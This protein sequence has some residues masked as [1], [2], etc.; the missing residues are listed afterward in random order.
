MTRILAACRY[1]LVVPLIGC[2]VLIQAFDPIFSY[3]HNFDIRK[4]QTKT[5]LEG[6][7]Q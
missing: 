4:R 5:K 3:T 1:L 2:V 7:F 6:D